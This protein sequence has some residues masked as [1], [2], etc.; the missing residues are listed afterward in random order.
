MSNEQESRVTIITR[1]W[2]KAIKERNRKMKEMED[3]QKAQGKEDV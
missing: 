3:R 1:L 2:D